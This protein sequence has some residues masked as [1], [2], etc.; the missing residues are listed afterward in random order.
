MSIN[1]DLIDQYSVEDWNK[2]VRGELKKQDPVL[3]TKVAESKSKKLDKVNNAILKAHYK[4]IMGRV[5]WGGKHWGT[6]KEKKLPWTT[7][8]HKPLNRFVSQRPHASQFRQGKARLRPT[9]TR[10]RPAYGIPFGP[11]HLQRARANL[12]T[13]GGTASYPPLSQ[14]GRA[15]KKAY[16]KRI[17]LNLRY[18]K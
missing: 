4:R 2:Y 7:F 13:R 5:T 10:R 8:Y 14:L 18:R 15:R 16:T 9:Y 6:Y 11:I 12:R 1:W 17:K 3:S